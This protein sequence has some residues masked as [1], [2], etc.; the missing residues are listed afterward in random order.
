MQRFAYTQPRTLSEA[1]AALRAYPNAA[2][3]AGGV[4]LLDLMQERLV[5]PEVIVDLDR[6]DECRGV[7]HDAATGALRIG[8]LTTLAEVAAADTVRAGWPALT[9][10]ASGAATPQIRNQ[11][12]L[13]GNL[14][15]RP[16]CW[17]FR[18]AAYV[19]R[20]KGGATCYAQEGDNRYHAVFG[21]RTCAMTHPSGAAVP[22]LAYDAA[23]DV[24][25]VTGRM[26]TLPL[27][28]FFV[29][30]EQ[31]VRRENVLA[32]G[33][34]IT[35]VT[36][37]QPSDGTAGAYLNLKHKQSFDWPL[38]EAAVVLTQRAGVVRGAR[39]VLGSVAPTPLRSAAAEAAL[40]GQA[41]D[42][43]VA[44]RAGQ[45]AVSGAQPLAH[46]A[47]KV[48]LLAELVRRAV[49]KAAGQLPAEDELE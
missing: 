20:K 40:I 8:S 36:L 2:L 25:D 7:R 39:I 37:P 24:L 38:A 14:C 1:A 41:V 47:E 6:I 28:E 4:D 12:T 46:N 5:A 15:Q 33:D 48:P 9:D 42:L 22:L 23:L 34:V 49:L 3:K 43:D 29:T 21:H 32:A 31:D 45:A 30:P 11:A 10:M 35:A 17:Y 18:Q 19:C 13:G 26:R 44:E 27:A 16:R